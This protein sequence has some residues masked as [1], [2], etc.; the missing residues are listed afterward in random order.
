MN[1]GAVAKAVPRRSFEARQLPV[2]LPPDSAASA[3][4]APISAPAP[5]DGELV[6]AL[7]DGMIDALLG[8]RPIVYTIVY[9]RRAAGRRVFSRQP[10]PPGALPLLAEVLRIAMLDLVL[11]LAEAEARSGE[12]RRTP[13]RDQLLIPFTECE[14]IEV[15]RARGQLA[16]QGQLPV[17]A[18]EAW[19]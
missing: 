3:R 4:R 16:L 8:Y 2:Q 9:T 6:G 11:E 17:K 10:L 1:S 14:Q 12:A 5:T 19:A 7:A 15:L 18:G 13:P